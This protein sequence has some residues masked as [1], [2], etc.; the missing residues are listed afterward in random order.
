MISAIVLAAGKSARMGKINK[1][2]L[3]YKESTVIGTVVA[4]LG[5][6]LVDEII[7]VDNQDARI[8]DHF[9]INASLK[10][11]TNLDAD[12]G[13]TS[14]IQCGVKA[15]SQNPTGI[16]VCLGDMP[17]LNSIDYNLLI[18]KLLSIKY[19]AILMPIHN[20]KRGN[21]VLFSPHFKEEILSLQ[22]G[23]GCKPVV[24]ANND[25]VIEIPFANSNCH[26]DIDTMDDYKRIK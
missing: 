8:V 1:M 26:V 12:Q 14:S 9:D 25:F 24:V 20:N 15:V 18:N 3:P 10:F 17:L 22:D 4:A 23:N 7:I 16:L 21:P 5:K 13:L 11:V 19:K 6:S 2:L